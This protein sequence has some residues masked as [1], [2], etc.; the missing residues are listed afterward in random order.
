MTQIATS[1]MLLL[2]LMPKD[3]F[4]L[5][6]QGGA[7]LKREKSDCNKTII[8]RANT[9]GAAFVILSFLCKRNSMLSMP[10]LFLELPPQNRDD[11]QRQPK[12]LFTHDGSFSMKWSSKSSKIDCRMANE[13]FQYCGVYM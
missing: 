4:D 11:P 13:N 8:N 2:F 12:T 10:P 9:K 5:E 6:L 7:M 3:D 1:N